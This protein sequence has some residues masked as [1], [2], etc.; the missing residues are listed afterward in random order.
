MNRI[1]RALRL[2]RSHDSMVESKASHP[3]GE[4]YSNEQETNYH[5]TKKVNVFPNV[6]KRNR[7]ISTHQNDTIISAYKI[8]RT[9]VLQRMKEQG[10]STLGISSANQN[11]GKSLTA[12]NLAISLAQETQHTVLLVDFDLREP[13]VHSYFEH[14][15]EYGVSDYFLNDTPIEDILFNPGID[16]LVVLP[17]IKPLSNSSE[18]LSSPKTIDLVNEL[19]NRYRDRIIIFDLPPLLNSDDVMAFSPYID[20]AL[21]VIEDGKT[22]RDGLQQALNYLEKTPLL[23]TVLNKSGGKSQ[24]A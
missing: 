4:R 18:A 16:D 23:G 17:S 20:S 3:I 1:K 5:V 19:K 11:E 12:I 9:R 6:L 2:V 10:W 22:G 7:V 14:I 8:L 15:P 24:F 13:S 21:L